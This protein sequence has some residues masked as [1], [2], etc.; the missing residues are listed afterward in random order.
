MGKEYWRPLVAPK[1]DLPKSALALAGGSFG[2]VSLERLSRDHPSE[3]LPA[4]AAPAGILEKLTANRPDICG[5][6]M[7]TANV[8]GILNVTPN[9]FSD[10]GEFDAPERAFEHARLMKAAGADII[11][12]GGESTRPG[13]E[14]VS[15]THEAAR[16]LPV[17][18]ALKENGIGPIS[19][20]TRNASTAQAALAK[21]ADMF[22]DVSAL[23]HDPSSAQIAA[24]SNKPICLMHAQGTPKTMQAEPKYDDVL[25]DVFDWLEDRIN[26]AVAAGIERA[27][28]VID[29]GIGFGKTTAHN[30]AL[31]RGLSLFHGLGVPILVGA[32]RKR[33]IGEIADVPDAQQ[34]LPGS[35]AVVILATTQGAQLIR[36]HDVGE[37]VQALKLT[38]AIIN[39]NAV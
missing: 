7:A 12:I 31:L 36:V 35:L 13:A 11:D 26:V 14:P 16:V 4:S 5:L 38:K 9:S 22:N 37:T 10:G 1:G 6:N 19:I 39:P 27:R 21:G 32:S 25:L 33:F 17:I 15:A 30:L 23:T 20:D 8:M 28:I 34:R 29:P 2:F 24:S 18:A 3:V